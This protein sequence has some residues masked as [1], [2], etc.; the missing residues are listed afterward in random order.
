MLGVILLLAGLW[1]NIFASQAII[2]AAKAFA[3]GT[4]TPDQ[5]RLVFANND[6]V[7]H[8][9]LT[10][11]IDKDVYQANQ[12]FFT[13]KNFEFSKNAAEKAGLSLTVQDPAN[14]GAPPKPGAD[15]DNILQ[16]G[17]SGKDI[18]LED[19]QRVNKNYN[20][21]V[22]KWLKGDPNSK[23]PGDK[24]LKFRD[25]VNWNKKLDTDF[26]P[27]PGHTKEFGKITRGINKGGGTAYESS[28]AARV[29]AEIRKA[30]KENRPP[31]INAMEAARYNK[32][33]DTQID[34]KLT[35]IEK[36]NVKIE[37]MKN[38]NP[39]HFAE[40]IKN[41]QAENQKFQCQ[42]AKYL[43]RKDDMNRIVANNNKVDYQSKL[44]PEVRAAAARGDGSKAPAEWV[45]KNAKNLVK[46][47][48]SGFRQVAK[49]VLVSKVKNAVGGARD[50]L[51]R[52]ASNVSSWL[53][54]KAT[55]ARNYVSN[56]ALGQRVSNMG[57]RVS[58]SSGGQFVRGGINLGRAVVHAP[59][60]VLNKLGM[61]STNTGVGG[62]ALGVGGM[63][64]SGFEIYDT[65]K[66]GYKSGDVK[67]TAVQL[68]L[69]AG[70]N[71][72]MGAAM[73]PLAAAMPHTMVLVGTYQVSYGL[74]REVMSRVSING[75]TLDEHTQNGIDNQIFISSQYDVA[76]E[77]D[78]RQ[79][80]I[81]MLKKGYKLPP[82]MKV[83]DGWKQ[84]EGNLANG[85][86]TFDGIFDP[87]RK[88]PPLPATPG[89]PSAPAEPA[90]GTG[91]SSKTIVEDSNI[92]NTVQ[93]QYEASEKSSINAGIEARGA[94]IKNSDI[95]VNTNANIKASGGSDVNAGV[96]LDGTRVE[97]KSTISAHTTGK[98]EAKDG[99]VVN[100][101]VEANR[102]TVLGSKIS[103][104][105]ST[106]IEASGKGTEVNTGVQA[107]D[108]TIKNSTVSSTVLGGKIEASEGSK[109][110]AG[111]KANNTSI[112]NSTIINTV[113][114]T[115][116]TAK[117]KSDVNTGIKL[118][119]DDN[120]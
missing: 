67:G 22:N 69:I 18:T 94:T 31:K 106:N 29:E 104:E 14:P 81:K 37:A 107:N 83:V 75:K 38:S 78:L 3:A 90:P 116:A 24:G 45:G 57:T 95:I 109:V 84:I 21:E 99:A 117:K 72:V 91:R 103:A 98:I 112:T 48:N 7:N 105:S 16:K 111:V 9:A 47:T 68:G 11:R 89:K 97:E 23:V 33:M 100:T 96:R 34:R 44:P 20:E 62:K 25:N 85:K 71:V 53:G 51:G 110:N 118:E 43:V 1:T 114:G 102:S 52:Q 19:H 76:A 64:L 115:T 32:E 86:K 42:T 46:E 77:A 54:G 26:M 87:N 58:N 12:K 66:Q 92:F 15:T 27:D 73:A 101:G 120:K 61:T 60:K 108:A 119:G 49:D 17:R 65:I 63:I 13:E 6:I 41:L 79:M 80:Y 40:K 28:T 88:G 8:L 59:D 74:T 50:Y 55:E 70:R 5:T 39:T 36:N 35:K 56:S 30:A 82:G 4:A 93:G 113:T 10:G 2:D